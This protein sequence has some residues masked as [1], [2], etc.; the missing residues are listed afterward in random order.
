MKQE[1]FSLRLKEG[2]N[3]GVFGYIA[4]KT[5]NNPLTTAFLDTLKKEFKIA[6]SKFF[7]V[8]YGVDSAL[9][10]LTLNYPIK[11]TFLRKFFLNDAQANDAQANDA[12]VNDA[13]VNDMKFE[14]E[15]KVYLIH[16]TSEIVL[17]NMHFRQIVVEL[18]TD[19]NVFS[20]FEKD[21]YPI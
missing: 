5:A 17:D 16:K 9:E 11:A 10:G 19:E 18:E 15:I 2:T 14:K 20:C 3:K 8:G 21:I 13:Q 6:I 1:V 7:E 12:Q 4:Y